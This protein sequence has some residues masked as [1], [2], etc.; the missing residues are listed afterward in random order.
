MQG[1]LQVELEGEKHFLKPGDILHVP[2]GSKHSFKTKNGSVFEEVSTTHYTD[3][4]FYDD[5]KIN[6]N[7]ERESFIPLR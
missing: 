6:L 5:K 3:D 1:E 2:I 4:S 7:E